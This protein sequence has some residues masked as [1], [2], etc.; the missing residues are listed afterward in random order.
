MWFEGKSVLHELF[1]KTRPHLGRFSLTARR[2]N[3]VP[4]AAPLLREEVMPMDVSEVVAFLERCVNL[5][6]AIVRFVREVRR[7]SDE[8]AGRKR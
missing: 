3:R 4:R 2:S 6:L 8:S 7:R 1:E 5:A